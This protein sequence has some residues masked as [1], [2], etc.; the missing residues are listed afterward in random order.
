MPKYGK[1]LRPAGIR[2]GKKVH[3]PDVGCLAFI[4]FS[5]RDMHQDKPPE[6]VSP[7]YHTHYRTNIFEAWR[8]LWRG[9]AFT[10]LFATSNDYG[11]P[12]NPND[13]SDPPDFA[14]HQNFRTAL[15]DKTYFRAAV[16]LYE[17]VLY[18]DEAKHTSG[19]EGWYDNR[20]GCTPIRPRAIDPGTTWNMLLHCSGGA[21]DATRPGLF[22][23]PDV[24][25]AGADGYTI[26]NWYYFRMGRM[27]RWANRIFTGES[28]PY[29]LVKVQYE[30]RVDWTQHCANVKICFG[31][32]NI[33]SQ[34]YYADWK[35]FRTHGK[36]EPWRSYTMLWLEDKAITA[37]MTTPKDNTPDTDWREPVY[38]AV[39]PFADA[40]SG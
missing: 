19:L 3:L 7:L 10:R 31:G 8:K 39:V 26:H 15:A 34:A 33:P 13:P 11:N 40:T 6:A 38:E 21:D 16:C 37:F 29:C 4:P 18:V 20:V 22:S 36:S 32:S 23:S 17:L 35:R 2:A 27:G 25:L 1:P 14:S 28:T 30:V 5:Y 24:S 12:A 9:R